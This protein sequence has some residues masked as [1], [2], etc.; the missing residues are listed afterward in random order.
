MFDEK[1]II[2]FPGFGLICKNDFFYLLRILFSQIKK[3]RRKFNN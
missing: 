1:E 2:I 3:S